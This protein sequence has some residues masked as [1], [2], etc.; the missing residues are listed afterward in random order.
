MLKN[1]FIAFLLLAL[2]CSSPSNNS[3]VKTEIQN[4]KY[5]DDEIALMNMI[6][7]Y[8]ES[9]GLHSLDT[10]NHM[11]FLSLQH[12]IYMIEKYAPSHDG[13]VQRSDELIQLF[14][15]S[16]VGENVA[17]NYKLNNDVFRAWLASSAHKENIEGE[18]THFGLSIRIDSTNNRKYY[19]NIFMKVSK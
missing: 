12:N 5:I 16:M 10:I 15:A 18:F 6:N 17:Y 2:S 4:Y 13:F 1:R 7:N 11:S 19:T 9:I 8:R 14:H 3:V